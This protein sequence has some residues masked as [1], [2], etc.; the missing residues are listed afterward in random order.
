M[1]AGR[2]WPSRAS[3]YTLSDIDRKV[4]NLKVTIDE[5]ETF[6]DRIID[7][8]KTHIVH[9]P[10]GEYARLEEKDGIDVL[11]NIIEA[12]ILSPNL[13]YY[14]DLHNSLHYMIAYCHDPDHRYLVDISHV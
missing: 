4:D 9:R 12:S 8:I 5:M 6:R 2:A 14:G 1:V 10:N 11:G 13:E 7:T 3:G